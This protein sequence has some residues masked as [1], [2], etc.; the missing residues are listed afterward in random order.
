MKLK[1]N[2][3]VFAVTIAWLAVGSQVFGQSRASI[4]FNTAWFFRLD[5]VSDYRDSRVDYQDWRQLDLPHDWSIELPFDSLSAG[6]S[7]TGYLSGGVGWYKKSFTLSEEESS[8]RVY[9]ELDRKSTR[10]NSSHVKISYA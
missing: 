3:F 8:K 9:I 2:I 4:D 6:S 5:S 1:R 7:G 10:L